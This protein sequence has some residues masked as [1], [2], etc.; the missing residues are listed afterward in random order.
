MHANEEEHKVE[1]PFESIYQAAIAPIDQRKE[2]LDYAKQFACINIRREEEMGSPVNKLAF[3]KNVD[4]VNFLLGE[5]GSFA[6]AAFG[7][8]R[9]GHSDEVYALLKRVRAEH[10]LQLHAVIKKIAQGFALAGEKGARELKIFLDNKSFSIWSYAA[11][12]HAQRGDLEKAKEILQLAREQSLEKMILVANQI[13]AGLVLNGAM[14][15]NTFFDEIFAELCNRNGYPLKKN[16]EEALNSLIKTIILHYAKTGNDVLIPRFLA[17]LRSMHIY[18]I[19]REL[20]YLVSEGL[21]Q[22]GL[23]HS[24]EYHTEYNV[25]GLAMAGYKAAAYKVDRTPFFRGASVT[26][27]SEY[28]HMFDSY[29]GYGFAALGDVA[30]AYTLLQEMTENHSGYEEALLREIAK[31]FASND[32]IEEALQFVK[33][34]NDGGVDPELV[35]HMLGMLGQF[36]GQ[37]GY[38]TEAYYF[39]E[40][41]K[42]ISAA[43]GHSVLSEIAFGLAID[44]NIK[45]LHFLLG[46]L[47]KENITDVQL[48]SLL[49]HIMEGFG[50]KDHFQEG[51][52]FL[53]QVA[54]IYPTKVDLMLT[55]LLHDQNLSERSYPDQATIQ[56]LFRECISPTPSANLINE[57][58]AAKIRSVKLLS[59]AT[60]FKVR[61]KK[62]DFT[63]LELAGWL[64]PAIQTLLLQGLALG[65]QKITSVITGYIATF[66]WR[67]STL[68]DFQKFASKVQT[69]RQKKEGFFYQEEKKA[70]VVHMP[71]PGPEMLTHLT[72]AMILSKGGTSQEILSLCKLITQEN[73]NTPVT[74]QE[75]SNALS[76]FG[77]NNHRLRLFAGLDEPNKT[78]TDQTIVKLRDYFPRSS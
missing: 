37:A 28:Q 44:G 48:N 71:R 15:V 38:A 42:K 66:L 64:T 29:M 74:H 21:G 35:T 13:A 4:A 60:E 59:N 43:D 51:Y 75:I 56:R 78:K 30:S 18:I 25:R 54:K 62:L 68:E 34:M 61:A 10:P 70:V 7:Y 41:A 77:S 6:E 67:K 58:H 16:E 33:L 14:N 50:K 63:E 65:K 31:G 72:L 49:D 22:A 23:L 73:L 17:K 40:E 32:C 8:A 11:L 69:M 57:L 39:W 76:S 24:D 53:E 12:G 19:S 20:D 26:K 2:R 52:E 27:R 45:M 9:G 36:F 3:E 1:D 46:K 5:G 55:R 47:T